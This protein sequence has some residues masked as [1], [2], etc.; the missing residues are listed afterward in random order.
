MYFFSYN[1]FCN[2]NERTLIFHIKMQMRVQ[3]K[4]RKEAGQALVSDAYSSGFKGLNF[5]V[6]REGSRGVETTR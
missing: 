1:L 5:L 4:S 3:L 6:I 2:K